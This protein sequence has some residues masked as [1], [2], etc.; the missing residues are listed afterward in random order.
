MLNPVLGP[1][2]KILIISFYLKLKIIN[3]VNNLFYFNEIKLPEDPVSYR[4]YLTYY[5]FSG[6]RVQDTMCNMVIFFGNFGV[7]FNT[8][9][10]G[11]LTPEFDFL[12]LLPIFASKK[13]NPGVYIPVLI[14]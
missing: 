11:T 5:F 2:R 7:H 14:A 9:K 8:I 10:T 4:T 3:Y 13:L 6:P 1:A 12:N